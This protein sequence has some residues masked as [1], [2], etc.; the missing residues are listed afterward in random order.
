[1]GV[2]IGTSTNEVAQLL[3]KGG[4]QKTKTRLKYQGIE[5]CKA[6]D[7]INAGSKACEYGCLGFGDCVEICP[8]DAMELN[9]Q[10]LPEIDFDKCTGC[11]KCVEICPR[12]I[13]VLAPED[14]KNH[15]RCSSHDEGKIV[16]KICE[17][18][19]IGCGICVRTC[20]VD[21]ITMEDNLAVIDYEK[22]VNCGLCAEK[23]PTNTIEFSGKKIEEITI[24]DKCVGCT[25]C[26]KACPVDAIDGEIK[27]KH[28]IDQEQ[29][30]KCGICNDT[31]QVDGAI[32]VKYE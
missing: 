11:G 9:E 26:V 15:I 5:S 12:N 10:G 19:C 16:R 27:E 23:C 17:V 22:C 4:T 31:C 6:A 13:L 21:A 30:I 20:P 32:E 7:T 28:E 29:C 8:F 18:G 25:R 14:K 24:T 1:L 2:E 3:C